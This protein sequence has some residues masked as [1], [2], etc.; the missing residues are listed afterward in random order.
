M[1][2][3]I[4]YVCINNKLPL[5]TLL[6]AGYSVKLIHMY[7]ILIYYHKKI[8]INYITSE[9]TYEILINWLPQIYRR[10]KVTFV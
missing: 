9:C 3:I 2:K 10:I 4:C 1:Y 8:K 5:P 7:F 6:C